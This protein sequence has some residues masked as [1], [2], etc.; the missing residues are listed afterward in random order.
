M[1]PNLTPGPRPPRAGYFTP[2]P[3]LVNPALKSRVWTLP[4]HKV[5]YAAAGFGAV[6]GFALAFTNPASP[7]DTMFRRV[8]NPF[9]NPWQG[10]GIS[11]GLSDLRLQVWHGGGTASSGLFNSLSYDD[12]QAQFGYGGILGYHYSWTGGGLGGSIAYLN[13]IC[14]T[15]TTPGDV[16]YYSVVPGFTPTP[17][18][19]DASIILGGNTCYRYASSFQLRATTGTQT[20]PMALYG[21]TP[22]IIIFMGCIQNGDGYLRS[23]GTSFMLGVMDCNTGE[24]WVLTTRSVFNSGD[25]GSG[26]ILGYVTRQS[27]FYTD[28]CIA[29]IGQVQYASP[30]TYDQ[31]AYFVSAGADSFTIEVDAAGYTSDGQPMNV[32]YLAL[33]AMT[34]HG[35][36]SVGNGIQ[37]DTS[38]TAGFAPDVM[39]FASTQATTLGTVDDG[40]FTSIGMTDTTDPH[41]ILQRNYWEGTH[42]GVFSG[43]APRNWGRSSPSACLVFADDLSDVMM[44][45][46]GPP[47]LAEARAVLNGSG[48]ALTWPIDDA[49]A[50]Y[51]GWIAFQ[52]DVSDAVPEAT[53]GAAV[54]ASTSAFLT[55][56]IIPNTATNVDVYYYFEY[57]L[58]PSF[59]YSTTPALAGDGIIPIP[60]SETILGLDPGT[61]YYYRVVALDIAS[62][63]EFPGETLTFTTLASAPYIYRFEI[64]TLPR[65]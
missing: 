50:R 49:V 32:S 51:F 40:A 29:H 4:N 21:Q 30:Q 55:G 6:P 56:S 24:Q 26:G 45:V 43:G 12:G 18:A 58:S 13:P 19:G 10:A 27:S 61:L 14:P 52:V 46:P 15:N 1:P 65:P 53:T 63:C 39:L 35:Q 34:G 28:H 9:F 41:G 62:G 44:P 36:F 60:V 22:D 33:K 48:A 54:P 38:A 42:K 57:G 31:K 64:K 7:P 8:E 2:S 3:V 59:G 5:P 17:D 20:V 11:E 23:P 37:G 25:T 47:V 16:E